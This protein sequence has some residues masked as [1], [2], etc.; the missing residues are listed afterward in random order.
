MGSS[1][2][3]PYDQDDEWKIANNIFQ[4]LCDLDK[5]DREA[6]KELG[7]YDLKGFKVTLTKLGRENCGK[8]VDIKPR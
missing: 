3:P 4:R 1:E 6:G 2:Q 5:P 8:T 7:W